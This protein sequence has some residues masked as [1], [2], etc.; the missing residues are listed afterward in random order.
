M[1]FMIKKVLDKYME[2][3]EIFNNIIKKTNSELRDSQK[4]LIY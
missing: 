1:Y 3:W 2:I 4:Y